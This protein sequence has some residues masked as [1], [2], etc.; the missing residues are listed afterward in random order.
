[1]NTLLE[2]AERLGLQ[3]QE[4]LQFIRDQQEL[5]RLERI[6]AR[7]EAER[8]R[9]EATRQREE[10]TRQREEAERQRQHEIAMADRGL[11]NQDMPMHRRNVNGKAPK[12]PA[13]NDGK[14]DL[15]SYLQRFERF[16]R[17]NQW[18]DEEWAVSLSALLTG[19]ALEVYSRLSEEDSS[20]Y[21]R[22]KTALLKRYDLTEEGYHKKFRSSKPE[23]GESPEQFIYRIRTYLERWIEMSKC[24]K[25]YESVCNTFVKEQFINSCPKQL[26]IFL[27]ERATADLQEIAK[28]A[29]QYLNA[30][31][32]QLSEVNQN[33]K[34]LKSGD[35]SNPQEERE[36][37]CYNCNGKNHRASECPKPEASTGSATQG[38]SNKTC[39]YCR[40]PGHEIKD[41]WKRTKVASGLSTEQENP[42]TPDDIKEVSVGLLVQTDNQKRQSIFENVENDHLKLANGDSVSIVTNVCTTTQKNE[43][44]PVIEGLVNDQEVNC[45]RDTGCSGIVVKQKFVK[46]EQYTG[47]YG[48]M[49]LVDNTVRKARKAVINVDSPYLQ[50]QVEALCLPDAIYD[51]IIGNVP[52]ALPPDR[53]LKN[54]NESKKAEDGTKPKDESITIN[55]TA[56]TKINQINSNELYNVD[57]EKL[58]LL[59]EEDESIQ[60]CLKSKGT[61][62]HKYKRE[63]G[64]VYE[65]NAEN[66]KETTRRIVLPTKLRQ[67]IM[68]LAHDIPM[69]GHLGHKKTLD[70]IRLH[71][72]WP[73]IT[74]DVREYCNT[75]DICQFHPPD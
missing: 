14:D 15:H 68:N 38:R 9:E 2:Q 10:A 75:C 33:N 4:A 8:Q 19:K 63:N 55:Q 31:Q 51:L 73:G 16:A 36:I 43:G 21:E 70:R 7:E 3:G 22:L 41:C 17:T 32:S 50:G 60:N 58:K 48:Y 74:K 39:A 53:P 5:Q 40:K 27:K 66:G 11:N 13:F 67:K 46:E 45:L 54:W 44:M 25:T 35:K 26:S 12:L 59:Q 49:L 18:A 24:E 62:N 56:T 52:Q 42:E 6:E 65:F 20:N 64:I 71:F 29:E 61:N 30:H 1:M 69:A 34:Q 37:R 72:V 47:A 23:F 57:T 28:A